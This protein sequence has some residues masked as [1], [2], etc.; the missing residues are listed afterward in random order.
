MAFSLYKWII[1]VVCLELSLIDDKIIK[2]ITIKKLSDETNVSVPTINGMV[3]NKPIENRTK[4]KIPMLNKYEKAERRL[5][6]YMLYDEWKNEC[7]FD[8]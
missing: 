4:K 3:K 2:E 5:I 6:F 7:R 8:C 1:K